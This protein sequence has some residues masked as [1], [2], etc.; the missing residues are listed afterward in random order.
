MPNKPNPIAGGGGPP[1][2]GNMDRRL[3]VLE[4]RFDTSLPNLAMKVDLEALRADIRVELEKLRGEVRTEMEKL[5]VEVAEKINSAMKWM[6]GLFITFFIGV[7]GV[8]FAMLNALK[9]LI[10]TGPA[11]VAQSAAPAASQ[12]DSPLSPPAAKRQP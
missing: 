5:R 10:A 11:P 7:L 12:R 6:I 4:T 2:D 9:N 3:T 1:Y 8:N